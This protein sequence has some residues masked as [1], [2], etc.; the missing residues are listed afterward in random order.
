MVAV[1]VEPC[2][3][4]KCALGIAL[5]CA[6]G[7]VEEVEVVDFRVPELK[8]VAAGVLLKQSAG[9]DNLVEEVP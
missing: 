6:L 2:S 8:A 4:G 9:D 5:A 1:A 7:V 3:G